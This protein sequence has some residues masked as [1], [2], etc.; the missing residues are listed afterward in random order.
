[1]HMST[2][3]KG[4]EG[5]G[6]YEIIMMLHE[7]HKRGVSATAHLAGNVPE[8]MLLALDDLPQSFDEGRV[9]LGKT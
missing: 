5:Y 8:R 9:S 3:W 6:A 2:D 4:L 7:L 1:M